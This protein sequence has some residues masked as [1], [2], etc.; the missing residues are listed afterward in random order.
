MKTVR[1]YLQV[2]ISVLSEKDITE[3]LQRVLDEGQP[4]VG[5]GGFEVTNYD[6]LDDDGM[7]EEE[8]ECKH[9]INL[10]TVDGDLCNDCL[11]G[12]EI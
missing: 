8:I 2:D 11:E 6:I 1:V 4:H 3:T 10:V 7:D 5:E 9:C 12:E